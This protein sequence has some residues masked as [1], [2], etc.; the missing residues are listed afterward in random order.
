[1]SA[2]FLGHARASSTNRPTSRAGSSYRTLINPHLGRD[3]V[4][5]PTERNVFRRPRYVHNERLNSLL[6]CQRDF[7]RAASQAKEQFARQKEFFRF[8]KK[9][10]QL[11]ASYL[12]SAWKARPQQQKRSPQRRSQTR[13]ASEAGALL[14]SPGDG[15]RMELRDGSESEELPGG[16]VDFQEFLTRTLAGAGNC[17]D[18]EHSF[19]VERV[20]AAVTSHY[21]RI[22]E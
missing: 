6:N 22:N 11:S 1:M 14:L 18:I 17:E 12:D 16:T 21:F 4:D 3:V 20:I 2:K 5:E 19:N 15:P 13:I 10:S 7:D 9:H 8:Y